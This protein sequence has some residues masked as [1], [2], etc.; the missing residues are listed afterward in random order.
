MI[1]KKISVKRC[2]FAWFPMWFVANNDFP[3]QEYLKQVSCPI[4]F[5]QQSED[6]AGYYQSIVNLFS[7]ISPKF[8][9]KKLSGSDH[10]YKD[11]EAFRGLDLR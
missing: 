8:T 10:A 6:P 5:V 9:F 2:I 3:I 4:L 11:I 1:K 7:P